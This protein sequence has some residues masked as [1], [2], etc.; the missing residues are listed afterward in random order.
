MWKKIGEILKWH[1]TRLHSLILTLGCFGYYILA[2][3]YLVQNALWL[4]WSCFLFR[5]RKFD[6]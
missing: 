3:C 1:Q 4:P 6:R 2:T 5:G